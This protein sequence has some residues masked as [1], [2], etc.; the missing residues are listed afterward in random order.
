VKQ[1]RE[2]DMSAINEFMKTTNF[3]LLLLF[4]YYYSY[5]WITILVYVRWLQLVWNLNPEENWVSWS[6]WIGFQSF[7]YWMVSKETLGNVRAYT[8]PWLAS[9]MFF[10]FFSSCS[11]SSP[12]S[13][14]NLIV[15]GDKRND[16]YV[17]QKIKIK[18]E[19]KYCIIV[20][21]LGSLW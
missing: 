6:V 21:V 4:V 9:W 12:C 18:W 10:S 14:M 13:S 3:H 16:L 7:T 15:Y 2:C 17:K 8:K 11:S 1:R 5:H 19:R 20:N